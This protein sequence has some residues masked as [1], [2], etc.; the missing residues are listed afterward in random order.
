MTAECSLGEG[1]F[2]MLRRS[3]L[4]NA[5]GLAVAGPVLAACGARD[6]SD[7]ADGGRQVVFSTFGGG[8]AD[9]QKSVIL[10][11]FTKA[12]GIA[13]E[14]RTDG[15]DIY[16]LVK[17]Q[18]QTGRGDISLIHADSS[19]VPRGEQDHILR[20]IDRAKL[21]DVDQ[22]FPGVVQPYGVRIL[23]WSYNIT[24]NRKVFPGSHPS[25]WS[26]VWEYALRHP[27]KVALWGGRPNY[28]IEVALLA[29]GVG[30]ADLYPLTPAKIDRAYRSLDRI[31]HNVVFY[32][33]GTDG[34]QLF[35][36]QVDVGMYYGGNTELLIDKG[37]PLG[38]EYREGIYTSDFW[39][40]PKNAPDPSGAYALINYAL[41]ARVQASFAT[42]SKYGFVNSHAAADIHSREDLEMLPSYPAN[43][44]Q[45]IAYDYQWWG[46]HDNEQAGRWNTWLRG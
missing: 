40:I 32:N 8:F 15:E 31:K 13:V 25:T 17:R 14:E 43:K 18:V 23:Y 5:V 11:P 28:I 36:T 45:M 30:A 39:A 9:Q 38:L 10:K 6:A 46:L 3:L 42:V 7:G 33:D 1:D 2:G 34:D 29:D 44:D 24:Y 35:S 19:W 22:L 21:H 4:R 12:S 41:Q 37:V 20:P 26:E 16:A 27:K